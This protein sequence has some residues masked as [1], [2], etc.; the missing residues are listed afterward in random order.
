[1]ESAAVASGIAAARAADPIEQIPL[2]YGASIPIPGLLQ[3]P[4]GA[5]LGAAE[6]LGAVDAAVRARIDPRVWAFARDGIRRELFT[7]DQLARDAR[8]RGAMDPETGARHTALTPAEQDELAAMDQAVEARYQQIKDDPDALTRYANASPAYGPT[9]ALTDIALTPALGAAAGGAAT[10]GAEAVGAGRAARAVGCGADIA[11]QSLVD[12]TTPFVQGPLD[13]AVRGGQQGFRGM[14]GALQAGVRGV[15]DARA[16]EAPGVQYLGSGVVGNELMNAGTRTQAVVLPPLYPVG[17]PEAAV[18]D[19]LRA[20]A[21]AGSGRPA[22]ATG[23]DIAGLPS[24]PFSPTRKLETADPS[25]KGS[26]KMPIPV[27]PVGLPS[28]DEVRQAVDVSRAHKDWYFQIAERAAQLVGA[29]NLPEFFTIFGIT[30]AQTKVHDNIAATAQVMRSVRELRAAGK[31]WPEI[32]ASLLDMGDQIQSTYKKDGVTKEGVPYKKGD[33]RVDN[34]GEPV[35][36]YTRRP[37]IPFV[38]ASNDKRQAIVDAYETAVSRVE[39]GAKTSSYSG[40]F[41]SAGQ[42]VYDPRTTNDLWVFRG[43]NLTPKGV[44][45]AA[46]DDEA[47]RVVEAILNEIAAEKGLPGHNVQAAMWATF[48]NLWEQAPDLVSDYERGTKRLSQMLQ[49]GSERVVN[50]DGVQHRLFDVPTGQA[51]DFDRPEVKVLAGV[52]PALMRSPGPERAA[53]MTRQYSGEGEVPR[54]RTSPS[55][56]G[57]RHCRGQSSDGCAA[58]HAVGAGRGR[59]DREQGIFPW[60]TIPHRVSEVGGHAIVHLPGGTSETAQYVGAVLGDAVGRP[61]SS[62]RHGTPRRTSAAWWSAPRPS[63]SPSSA[64]ELQTAGL[65]HAVGTTRGVVQIP[66]LGATPR[67]SLVYFKQ[68]PCG[69]RSR[70]RASAPTLET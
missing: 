8:L 53:E 11:A 1:M 6:A 58:D 59:L 2:P 21:P 30:S 50:I 37:D 56:A 46:N 18:N 15:T 36:E 49:E 25:R 42:R 23:D 10:R 20:S 66:H 32:K 44:S 41:E 55:A 5:G 29:D 48:K 31:T 39:S 64:A 22:Q 16:A 60:L 35:R 69:R 54:P 38:L 63:R 47:Y 57:A 34:K 19:L 28:V 52:D 24:S 70:Q 33:G 12:P 7:P 40:S 62:V 9:S 65:P 67:R 61:S 43:F 51:Q 45:N 13:L 17:T 4:A 68:P 3:R 14:R 27:N 26:G